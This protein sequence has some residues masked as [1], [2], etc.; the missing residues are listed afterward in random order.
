MASWQ[1]MG[2]W[3]EEA[4]RRLTDAKLV[5]P[6]HYFEVE[7]NKV[8]MLALTLFHLENN[9]ILPKTN[10]EL[11]RMHNYEVGGH[12]FEFCLEIR[13]EARELFAK[14]GDV[15]RLASWIANNT[16][17]RR[18]VRQLLNQMR[19]QYDDITEPTKEL[20]SIIGT[21]NMIRS[22]RRS[23]RNLS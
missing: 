2:N 19:I 15:R 18:E 3:L 21:L 13:A 8:L 1:L 22:S 16:E 9:T 7:E 14:V 11:I 20:L 23:P 12:P 6:D 17:S 4:V 5:D 10:G